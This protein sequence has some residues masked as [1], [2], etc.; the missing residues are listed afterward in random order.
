VPDRAVPFYTMTDQ[1]LCRAGN[2]VTA[3]VDTRDG[4]RE[5]V[6]RLMVAASP[7]REGIR[8]P[9][10]RPEGWGLTLINSSILTVPLHAGWLLRTTAATQKVSL[11]LL[12][13]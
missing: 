8:I 7:L 13:R 12:L 3:G 11:S 5:E 10:Q 9:R 2:L 1:F 4:V 6:E